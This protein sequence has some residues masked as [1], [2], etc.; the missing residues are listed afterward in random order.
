MMLDLRRKLYIAQYSRKSECKPKPEEKHPLCNSVW[1]EFVKKKYTCA[2]A[3]L[4]VPLVIFLVFDNNF[5]LK[6]TIPTSTS[7]ENVWQWQIE[8]SWHIPCWVQG[9]STNKIWTSLCS[10]SI[11]VF[12]NY[13][14]CLIWIL[15]FPTN[16]CPFKTDLSGNTVWPQASGFQ[17]LAKM[18]HFWHF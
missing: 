7:R 11:T 16:F 1:Q 12:E 10:I 3:P 13:S 6:P 8:N 14:K 4:L 2:S 17:K 18:N 9:W 5:T 15:A